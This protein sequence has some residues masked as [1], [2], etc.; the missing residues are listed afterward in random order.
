[1]TDGSWRD[2]WE[3]LGQQRSNQS[4]LKELSPEYSLE[5]QMLKL[6]YFGQL[7]QRANSLE[8][9]LIL[10]KTEGKKRRGWQR[11]RWLD[12]F[13]NSMNLS[14]N[15]LQDREAWCAAVHRV[16][17]SWPWLSN[18]T[19]FSYKLLNLMYYLSVITS[20]YPYRAAYSISLYVL[21]LFS[22]C[23]MGLMILLWGIPK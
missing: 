14:L 11:M 9:I 21:N 12:G 3:S 17:K 18:W 6:Q 19:T 20:I 15:K 2:S 4:I 5:G 10:G 1:M 16:T 7:M 22:L 23:V 13:I 8:K